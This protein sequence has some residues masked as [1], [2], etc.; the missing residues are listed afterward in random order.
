MNTLYLFTSK[1]NTAKT[2]QWEFNPSNDSRGT[3]KSEMI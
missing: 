1:H 3:L 2:I